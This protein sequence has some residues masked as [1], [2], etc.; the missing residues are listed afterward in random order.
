VLGFRAIVYIELSCVS[1]VV[2]RS[3]LSWNN[4]VYDDDDDDDPVWC[5]SVNDKGH[6]CRKSGLLFYSRYFIS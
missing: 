1:A 5:Q 4:K 2:L 6:E 3:V